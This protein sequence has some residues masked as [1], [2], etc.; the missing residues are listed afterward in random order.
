MP[1]RR[2]VRPGSDIAGSLLVRTRPSAWAV[3]PA[4]VIMYRA[5]RQPITMDKTG[6]FCPDKEVITAGHGPFPRA[7]AA[8]GAAVGAAPGRA[9]LGAGPGTDGVAA[10]RDRI[11]RGFRKLGDGLRLHCPRAVR[12]GQAGT[13]CAAAGARPPGGIAG[14]LPPRIPSSRT[15]SHMGPVDRQ[16]GKGRAIPA[17][18]R[19]T[20][21]RCLQDPGR[22]G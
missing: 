6:S 7:G 19:P 13:C 8:V 16:A 15:G 4:V 1:S 18:L 14:T 10:A 21:P 11:S 12:R 9:V 3:L 2:Q 5:G 20:G 17:W 22:T